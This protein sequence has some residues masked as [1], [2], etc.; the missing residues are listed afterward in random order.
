MIE[1]PWL[2]YWNLQTNPFG[3]RASP[4]IPLASHAEVL[5]RLVDAIDSGSRAVKLSAEPGMG[6]STLL[7]EALAQIRHP[8]RRL[9]S[10][11]QPTS[12]EDVVL[13]V[14]RALGR[15]A[16]GATGWP[17]LLTGLNLAALQNQQVVIAID[18]LRGLDS[19][20]TIN[21]LESVADRYAMTIVQVGRPDDLTRVNRD[22]DRAIS[23]PRL[24]RSETLTYLMAKWSW[25]GG[26]SLAIE[27]RGVTTLH[28]VAEGVPACLNRIIGQALR[29]VASRRGS[30]VTAAD[31]ELVVERSLMPGW[32]VP[33]GIG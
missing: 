11:N 15:R 3:P 5:S 8:N 10:I 26:K 27:P 7:R 21:L 29:D 1:V 22:F 32:S 14:A 24:S 6:K 20:D 18:D 25:A 17:E 31:V 9:V 13:R 28:G 2:A 23:L 19:F 33:R 30:V 12:S 16:V 4:F